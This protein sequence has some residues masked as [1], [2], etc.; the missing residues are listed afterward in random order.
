MLFFESGR[1]RL[2]PGEHS[3]IYYEDEQIA[4]FENARP[5]L[6]IRWELFEANA[7]GGRLEGRNAAGRLGRAPT[8]L[9]RKAKSAPIGIYVVGFS[10][11]RRRRWQPIRQPTSVERP[12]LLGFLPIRI[13]AFERFTATGREKRKAYQ[14]EL[15]ARHV[16]PNP[17]HSFGVVVPDAAQ[18]VTVRCWSGTKH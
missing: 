15:R 3:S 13:A 16:I 2:A 10:D 14:Q 9:D 5:L 6:D 7:W 18:R 8:C 17:L 1:Y 11:V 12:V 4:A